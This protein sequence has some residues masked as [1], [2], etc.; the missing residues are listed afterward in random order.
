[1]D[2]KACLE[3]ALEHVQDEEYSEALYALGD[4]FDW[5]LGGGCEPRGGDKRAMAMQRKIAE[6]LELAGV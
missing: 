2:P 5:R 3:R 6:V 4:Y 1:M